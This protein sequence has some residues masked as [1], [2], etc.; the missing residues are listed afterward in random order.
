MNSFEYQ[1]PVK[2]IFGTGTLNRAGEEIAKQGRKAF[3]VSYSDKG[4]Q[5]VLDRLSEQLRSSGLKEKRFLEV[6]PNPDI[7]MVGRGIQQAKDWGADVV[8]G[9]GGG[10]A[11]DT[12]KAIAAGVL[13]PIDDPW[14]MVYSRHD[15]IQ[16]VVPTETLPTVMIPTLPATGSEMNNCSVVSNR[17]LGEK[18]Y[19]WSACL[20]PKTAILDPELTYSLP[21]FQT[22]CGGIDTISHVLEIYVNGQEKS[23]LLHAWQ[24]GVMKTVL[25]NLPMALANPM[26]ADARTELMWCATCALNGWASPGDAWTPIHQLGHVL[27]SRHQINHGSSLG[28]LMPAWIEVM[29]RYRPQPYYRF[30][31][32]VMGIDPKSGTQ[33]Q[34]I[35]A[36][37]AA[38]RQYIGDSGLPIRLSEKG[39][40]ESDLPEIIK[41]VRKVSFN[42]DGVLSGNPPITED[43]L[44]AILKKAL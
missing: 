16:A 22:A 8:V 2:V 42:A 31:V 28:L 10:S 33:Q 5:A 13:Y 26:D 44:L 24:E 1:N 30:A 38:F 29:K 25:K 18:S 12:A 41:G 11:M 14:K 4:C 6:M 43:M 20:F 15:N 19:I 36:G 7:L 37:S 32:N 9:V 34:V 23:D 27:T 17:A 39:V 21:A 3:V 35:D 40:V